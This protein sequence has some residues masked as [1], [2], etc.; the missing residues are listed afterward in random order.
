MCKVLKKAIQGKA[1]PIDV[2]LAKLAIEIRILID[3]PDLQPISA[4]E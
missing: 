1:R 3:E 4:P 2:N